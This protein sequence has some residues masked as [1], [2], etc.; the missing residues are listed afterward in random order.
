MS[1]ALGELPF[2][3]LDINLPTCSVR[4]EAEESTLEGFYFF[5]FLSELS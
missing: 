1:D 4:E 2:E 3:L 5:A